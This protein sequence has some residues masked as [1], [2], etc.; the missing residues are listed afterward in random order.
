MMTMMF[1]FSAACA[2]DERSSREK[3]NFKKFMTFL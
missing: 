1:G 3:I 2:T